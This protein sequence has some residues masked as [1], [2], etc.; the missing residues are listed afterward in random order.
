MIA[1]FIRALITLIICLLLG[2]IALAAVL[3]G[4]GL[5]GWAL[6][7]ALNQVVSPQV[8]ALLTGF[9]AFAMAVLFALLALLVLRLG[10]RPPRRVTAA[11]AA[12][13][14]VTPGAEYDAAA[15]LGGFIGSQAASMFR[16]RPLV[17]PIT[18]MAVGLAVGLSPRLRR[19]TFRFW[20]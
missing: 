8:A 17:A 16:S 4:V 1:F 3:G 18:A 6:Y 10:A 20:R 15:Q 5:L 14:P 9:A 19:A 2:M 12:G 7:M 11:P 13:V